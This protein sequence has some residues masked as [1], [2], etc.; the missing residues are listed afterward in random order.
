MFALSAWLP[1]HCRCCW[2]RAALE[3]PRVSCALASWIDLTW[4]VALAGRAGLEARNLPL[5]PHHP[6][7][8]PGTRGAVQ[9]FEAP[10]PPRCGSAARHPRALSPCSRPAVVMGAACL[11]LHSTVCLTMHGGKGGM[12]V[13]HQHVCFAACLSLCALG[14]WGQECG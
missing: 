2:C 6:L 8:G 10:H 3:S 7:R 1:Y 5:P 12:A 14:L 9:L 13:L 4:G 11:Q